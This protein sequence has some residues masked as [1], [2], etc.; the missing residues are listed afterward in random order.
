MNTSVEVQAIPEKKRSVK[1]ALL[2]FCAVVVS[3]FGTVFSASASTVPGANYLNATDAGMTNLGTLFTEITGW[4]TS[5]VSTIT[6]SPVL[7][8]GLGIFV[9]GAVIGL[10]YRLIRG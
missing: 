9:A 7:M 2:M 4:V 8:L 10:A 6:S 5:I 1:K 3:M